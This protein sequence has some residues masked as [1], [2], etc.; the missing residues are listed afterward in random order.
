MRLDHKI[1]LRATEKK[2]RPTR[3]QLPRARQ[4]GFHQRENEQKKSP[5]GA[6]RQHNPFGSENHATLKKKRSWTVMTT[7]R[8]DDD[9]RQT[10]EKKTPA[11]GVSSSHEKKSI[12][13][14]NSRD[15]RQGTC[16]QRGSQ[17][18][19][20]NNESKLKR[21]KKNGPVQVKNRSRNVKG[22]KGRRANRNSRAQERAAGRGESEHTLPS[23]RFKKDHNGGVPR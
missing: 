11:G 21:K 20:G 17:N 16:I 15:E 12:S 9:R 3:Y 22:M 4:N 23:S 14:R 1:G 5:T 2:Y 18:Q 19:K 7:N 13:A 6:F 8:Q 10:K